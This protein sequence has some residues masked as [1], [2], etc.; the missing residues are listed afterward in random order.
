M[1]E[2]LKRVPHFPAVELTAEEVY[3][4]MLD[5]GAPVPPEVTKYNSRFA[6]SERGTLVLWFDIR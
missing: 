6:V 2:E 1:F 5:K 4:C 3:Y